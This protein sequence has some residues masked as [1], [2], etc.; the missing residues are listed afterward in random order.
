[1]PYD[2]S[3]APPPRDMELIP[4]GTIAGIQFASAPAASA[5]TEC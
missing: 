5:R 3:Q 4:A 1:M 2:Y